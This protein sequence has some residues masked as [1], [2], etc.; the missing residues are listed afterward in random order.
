[1]AK[2]INGPVLAETKKISVKFVRE[3]KRCW[4]D[5]GAVIV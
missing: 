5:E 1:M 2:L 3:E 4:S